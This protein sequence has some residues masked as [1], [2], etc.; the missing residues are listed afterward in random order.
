MSR[1][2][3]GF[4]EA[5]VEV[6]RRLVAYKDSAPLGVAEAATALLKRVR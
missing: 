3:R 2:P 6:Y 1:C 5:A 4:H